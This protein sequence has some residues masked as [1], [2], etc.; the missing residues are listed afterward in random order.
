MFYLADEGSTTSTTWYPPDSNSRALWEVLLDIIHTQ[1]RE[2]HS[3][4]TKQDD[5]QISNISISP[6]PDM[7]R[8]V[9]KYGNYGNV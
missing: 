8:S 7:P 2:H 9:R 5:P 4:G 1:K 6:I 3:S